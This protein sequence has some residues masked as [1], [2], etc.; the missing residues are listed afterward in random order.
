MFGIV[1]PMFTGHRFIAEE[2]IPST[3]E[4]RVSG[5]SVVHIHLHREPECERHLFVLMGTQNVEIRQNLEA[6]C[7]HYQNNI[8]NFVQRHCTYFLIYD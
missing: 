8:R 4:I 5:A 1:I 6:D 3:N 7:F 2:L